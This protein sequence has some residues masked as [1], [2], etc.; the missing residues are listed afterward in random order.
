MSTNQPALRIDLTWWS[1]KQLKSVWDRAKS[2]LPVE[3]IIWSHIH[4]SPCLWWQRYYYPPPGGVIS[5]RVDGAL[6]VGRADMWWAAPLWQESPAQTMIRGKFQVDLG[7]KNRIY[8][9]T[10][11]WHYNRATPKQQK[12]QTI[13][14]I[15][16]PQGLS[17]VFSFTCMNCDLY[18][19]FRK[20][21]AVCN[22]AL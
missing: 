18:P 19:P 4:P 14:P 22:T 5:G 1:E 15:A 17:L 13:H 9:N 8:H 11:R 10:R 12:I 2:T 3:C 6:V 20:R 16:Q 21:S 7:S